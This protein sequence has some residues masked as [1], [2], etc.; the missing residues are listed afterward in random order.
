MKAPAFFDKLK[1]PAMKPRL[2]KAAL[3]TGTVAVIATVLVLGYKFG[4]IGAGGVGGG[5]AAGHGA[6]PHEQAS[7]EDHDSGDAHDQAPSHKTANRHNSHDAHGG[8]QRA[9]AGWLQQGWDTYSHAVESVQARVEELRRADEEVVRL[10]NENAHLRIALELARNENLAHQA[11]RD[12]EENAG[13]AKRDTWTLSGRSE[14]T[15]GYQPPEHLTPDQMYTLALSYF[16]AREDEKAAKI[17]S[18]IL[19]SDEAAGG[20]AQQAQ[21]YQTAANY[22]MA[23]IA[24]YRIDNLKVAGEFFAKAKELDKD[25][26]GD[27]VR[28]WNALMARRQGDHR[29]SQDYLKQVLDRNPNS[30]EAQWINPGAG[31]RKSHGGQR[32]L[33]SEPSGHSEH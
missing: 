31:S 28:L 27:Q 24:W 4:S 15:I 22:M 5:T 32:A 14:S 12:H 6:D 3:G 11:R 18:V 2:R 25:G 17:L 21:Q 8:H 30:M 33:A 26:V 29:K 7:A 16:K 20:V 13:K 1:D 10:R 19:R 9:S 23:G